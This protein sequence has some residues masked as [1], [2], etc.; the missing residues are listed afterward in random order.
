M[1]LGRSKLFKLSLLTGLFAAISFVCVST[2]APVISAYLKVQEENF[3]IY[4]YEGHFY[5]CYHIEGDS[6][7]IAIGWGQNASDTPDDTLTLP[8][9]VTHQS[10]TYTVKA[11]AKAGFRY[12]DFQSIVLPNTVEAIYEEAFA[13]CLN[14]TNFNLPYLVDKI[15]PSTFLDC[16]ALES[17]HYLNQAGGIA[18]GN[19]K[20]TEIGDHAFDSCVS[21][22]DFYC[23]INVTYFG[24]SS[25]QKC[26]KIVNF[27]FPSTIKN[28]QQEIT[29]YITVKPYAF[30]DCSSL[31]FIYFETNVK[32]IDDFAF[33]EANAAANIYYNGASEPVFKKD[34]VTQSHWRDFRI[35]TSDA[36]KIPIHVN[37]PSIHTD[38]AYPCLRYTIENDTVPLDSA[39]GRTTIDIIDAAEIAAEGSYAVLYK[40]DTPNEDVANCYDVSDGALTIPNTLGGK[41]V[42]IINSST[43]AN[44][45]AIRSVKFNQGLVQIR[46]RAFFDCTNIGALDFTLC[47][48]LKEVSYYIFSDVNESHKN[49]ELTSLLLPPC[50]EYIGGYAFAN[51]WNVNELV[52]PTNLKAF[53]DLAFYRLG[54]NITAEEADVDLLLPKSLND[55]DARAANFKHLPKNSFNHNNYTR[56]YAIGK[57]GFNEAKCIKTV[58][59]E[60]D[61]D[62]AN[63]NTYT[64]SL[65]SNAFN[66]ASNLA[67]FEANKNL[68]YLGKDVF[69]G[70]SGLKEVFLTYAK[71]QASGHDY[72]WCI[73]EEDGKYGGTLFFNT[74]PETVCYVDGPSAPGELDSYRLT[75]ENGSVQINTPWNAETA[76]SYVNE[77]KASRE[78]KDQNTTNLNRST[79][80]TYYNVNFKTDLK[81]WNPKTQAIVNAP[82]ELEHYDAGVV[83][84]IKRGENYTAV[85]Y[86]YNPDLNTGHDF[87][88][89]T[90][91]PGISDGTVSKLT[92]IGPEAFG[93]GLTIQGENPNRLR[94]PGHYFVLPETITKIG[95][96]AFFRPTNGSV[97]ANKNNGRYGVRCVTYKNSSGKYIGPDGSTQYTLTQ[98]MKKIDDD[99][100]KPVDLNKVGYCVLPNEITYIGKD[101]F[102]N[103]IFKNIVVGNKVTYFGIGAFSVN[104]AAAETRARTATFTMGSNS[105]FTHS[106]N[107][108]YYTKTVGKQFLLYQA[109]AVTG[110]LS[111]MANTN[112]I[113]M[114]ACANVRYTNVVLPTT[115]TTIYGYGFARSLTLQSVTGTSG[116]RYIGTMENAGNVTTTWSDPDYDEVY[117]DSLKDYFENTDFRDFAYKP[118][119]QIESIGGAFIGDNKLET[120]NF[121]AMTELRKIGPGS[122]SDCT[123][124]KKMSGSKSYIFKD[125]DKNGNYTTR[126]DRTNNN[127]NVL[128]LSGANSLRSIDRSA[129]TNCGGVKYCI[130]PDTKLPSDEES[131][132]Y[133]GFDPEAMRFDKS[134]ASIF[135]KDK[136]TN[137]LVGETAEY[138]HHDFGKTHNAQ[139]HYYST[140]FNTGNYI[141]YY[142]N[143]IYDIPSTD[144]SSIKYWTKNAAGEYILMDSAVIARK[145]FGI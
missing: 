48:K 8:S 70:C 43:F 60:D 125:Y 84:F 68:Q 73:N 26:E 1:K 33:V 139:N 97:D 92:E 42:K 14:M 59:M 7:G 38:P 24:E 95:E 27:Y 62:H 3:F 81:Y 127:E 67:R 112:A 75:T 35:T 83:G 17:I 96:R 34:G 140:C 10:R 143:S 56:F 6:E 61:P 57:Y 18:F 31:T 55:A 116:L 122:F 115:V 13:Y 109:Q 107:G 117:D 100:Q 144:T 76:G 37:Q 47:T 104:N 82:T 86:W 135:S 103:H 29:N 110:T 22:R 137:V 74:L 71:S 9:T 21:L 54:Y 123:S 72:P 130:L 51:L 145:Y 39:Q 131:K 28:D 4:E 11:I 114:Y 40:F 2:I 108:L 79:V 128:D 89:L 20:I 5:K 90:A 124:M 111:V 94:Q 85:K 12:C 52:L 46:N 66:G 36:T 99:M 93:R 132:I 101:A 102:Y 88:D 58:L 63:D 77:I 32:E 141:Y 69:K 118:R 136:K 98:F 106:N 105:I 15:Y 134:K 129:F 133:I 126:T 87:I 78:D 49:M 113:G 50:L 121:A 30:A 65:Y 64:T 119:A 45:K 142:A 19:D 23:P 53:D 80:A 120:I 138:A 25:F 16:R 44:N 41:T 91:V